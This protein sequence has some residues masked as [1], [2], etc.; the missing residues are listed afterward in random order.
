MKEKT[1]QHVTEIEGRIER[2]MQ[3][4]DRLTELIRKEKE[5]RLEQQRIVRARAGLHALS[6]A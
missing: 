3:R 6:F 5:E 4:A 1:N 2:L